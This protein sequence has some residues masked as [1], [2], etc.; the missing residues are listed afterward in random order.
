MRLDEIIPILVT[1]SDVF[2]TESAASNSGLN[3]K[4]ILSAD[5]LERPVSGVRFF[6]DH[7]DFTDVSDFISELWY[8]DGL[9]YL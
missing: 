2:I 6:P 1:Y 7:A 3:I 5:E 4:F 8:S 9:A